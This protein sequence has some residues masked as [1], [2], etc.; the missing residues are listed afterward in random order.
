M[1]LS[2]VFLYLRISL[3][4]CFLDCAYQVSLYVLCTD[5]GV[6]ALAYISF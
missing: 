3:V 2:A 5:F 6:I 1:Y 4:C